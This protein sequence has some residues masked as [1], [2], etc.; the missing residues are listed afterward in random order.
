MPSDAIQRIIDADEDAVSFSGFVNEPSDK[1]IQRRLAPPMN[2]LNYYRDFLHGLELVYSQQSGYVDVNGVQVKPVKVALDDALNAAVVGGGGLADTAVATVPQATGQIARQQSIKNTQTL[3]VS[4]FVDF[5]ATDHTAGLLA[6]VAAAKSL[7]KGLICRDTRSLKITAHVDMSGISRINFSNDI[8]CLSNTAKVTVGGFARTG[9]PPELYFMSVISLDSVITQPAPASPLFVVKGIKGGSVTIGSCNYMQIYA[10]ATSLDTSSNAYARFYLKGVTRKLE[11]T[12]SGVGQSWNNENFFYGGRLGSLFINGVSYVH[13]HNKF[14][15]PT[16]EGG[17]FELYFNKAEQNSIYGVRA[18]NVANSILTF[19]D[20]ANYNKLVMSW[21]WT[22]D[23]RGL[24]VNPFTTNDSGRVNNV[25]NESMYM[26]N[27]YP[28][29]T[30]DKNTVLLANDTDTA[31]SNIAVSPV[32]DSAN[33]YAKARLVPSVNGFV[34]HG[35]R[36]AV[37]TDYIEVNNGDVITCNADYEG[38]VL[39]LHYWLYDENMQPVTTATNA[40]AQT[41]VSSLGGEKYGHTTSVPSI[42]LNQYLG[43]VNSNLVKY[44]RVGVFSPAAVLIK[45][46]GF[47]LLTKRNN[48]RIASAAVAQKT[49]PLVL[50]GKPTMGYAPYNTLLFDTVLNN[51]RR[52]IFAHRTRVTTAISSTTT[53]VTVDAISSVAN[54]DIYGILLPSGKTSWGLVSGLTANSFTITATGEA[55][56]AGALIVF[57]RWSE[58]PVTT[59]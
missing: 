53:S 44:I 24:A 22:F 17:T 39:R 15:N 30:A 43:M 23:S 21:S 42:N 14:Y 40:F 7:N 10:D 59:P 41:A 4:E 12:D 32:S 33:I 6:A 18:E 35:N 50:Q 16:I 36:Y 11:L 38:N 8:Y 2:T 29:V 27:H 19:T 5:T 34:T 55:V 20:S 46:I 57:N 58:P 9:T 48:A 1:L 49:Q 47:G 51:Y 3:D 54:G 45:R 13:N 25:V 37:L 52:V 28:I 26:F 31:T 56:T